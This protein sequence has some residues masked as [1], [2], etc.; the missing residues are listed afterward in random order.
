MVSR[1]GAL[2]F[3]SNCQML[4]RTLKA[5]YRMAPSLAT[6]GLALVPIALF[7]GFSVDDA[8]IVTRI[9][10]VAKSTGTFS[11]NP[12][13]PPT[14]AVTPLGFAQL[15]FA[16]S[17]ATGL[18]PLGVAR[19]L[20][21]VAWG[22]TYFVAACWLTHEK[23]TFARRTLFGFLAATS[24]TGAAWAGAGLETPVI[25]WI[26]TSGLLLSERSRA[27]GALLA[28]MAAA[29][30][31]DLT[32][33]ALLAPQLYRRRVSERWQLL[34]LTVAPTAVVMG[35]RLSVFGDFLP[36]GFRAK[37]PDLSTGLRYA[38]GS[39]VLSGPFCFLI[40][41]R[42][43]DGRRLGAL[44]LVHF[45]SLILAGGDWMPLFR[46]SCPL[47]PWAS[48]LAIRSSR[49]RYAVPVAMILSLAGPLLLT[50]Y[51]RSD[52]TQVIETRGALIEKA[53]PKLAGAAR[54]ASVDIGWL[55]QAVEGNVVDLSGVANPR[56]ARLPGGHTSHRIP[57]AFLD[58]ERVDAWV[59][60]VWDREPG[61]NP[62]GQGAPPAP[63]R[64]VYA[65]D[66]ELLRG[67]E[68]L[69]FVLMGE[70][71]IARTGSSYAILR[72]APVL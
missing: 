31:P 72:R 45:L 35:I 15:L 22:A 52:A 41:A 58:R 70:L 51:Y 38:L 3:D 30:R 16:L 5:G 48:V 67:A 21:V 66:R 61:A 47:L 20:G 10:E 49:G 6:A 8:W 27:L 4:D 68:D 32:P 13:A 11:L 39:I 40:A 56:V 34:A 33:L 69:G 23:V 53:R 44:T 14:D 7:W 71:S 57:S 37:P 65:V 63:E 46:L 59:V 12:G 43:R 36:L 26:L 29:L 60:R 62:K 64:A 55:S 2:T 19:G 28:G 25:A 54:V 50:V 9:V 1:Q 42:G 24:V 17:A 18:P